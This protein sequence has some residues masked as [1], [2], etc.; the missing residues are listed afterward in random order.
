MDLK[1]LML[2]NMKV[3]EPIIKPNP[4][5]T[6]DLP[7]KKVVNN[8]NNILKEKQID[9]KVEFA[10]ILDTCPSKRIVKKF[11]KQWVEQMAKEVSK[12]EL[13]GLF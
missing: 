5:K 11:Y 2:S 9:P 4:E 8:A 7:L 12:N 3:K 1:Q 10:K 6:I 13:N